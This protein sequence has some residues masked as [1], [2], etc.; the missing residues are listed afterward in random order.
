MDL[1]PLLIVLGAYGYVRIGY[2][3]SKARRIFSERSDASVSDSSPLTLIPDTVSIALAVVMFL[4]VETRFLQFVLGVYAL[5]QL[6][7]I[8]RELIPIP[9][10][11]LGRRILEVL[12][13]L[14]AAFVGS[15]IVLLAYGVESVTD[16]PVPMLPIAVTSFFAV[17]FISF[18]YISK[19][20][21]NSETPASNQ[22]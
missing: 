1:S 7:R 10:T 5:S 16:P 6:Y 4:F 15:S 9:D 13:Y 18:T 2:S 19:E 14:S 17:I 8:G 21:S 22:P 12:Q 11:G 20:A 3:V